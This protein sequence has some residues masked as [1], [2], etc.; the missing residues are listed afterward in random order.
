[1]CTFDKVV[2]HDEGRASALRSLL[3]V[4]FDVDAIIIR[5][6]LDHCLTH[7]APLVKTPEQ[8]YVSSAMGIKPS[9]LAT[10]TPQNQTRSGGG[11]MKSTLILVAM[12]KF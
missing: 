1:M 5:A 11:D 4:G 9:G 2:D 3:G 7:A 10:S 6:L 8:M 12:V